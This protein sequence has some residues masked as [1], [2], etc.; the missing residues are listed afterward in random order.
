MTLSFYKIDLINAGAEWHDK[1]AV[2]QGLV[3][4]RNQMI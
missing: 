2:R 4:S 1:E 3:T